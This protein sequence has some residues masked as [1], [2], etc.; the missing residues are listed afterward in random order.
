L[1]FVPCFTAGLYFHV[2][3]AFSTASSTSFPADSTTR[4]SVTSPS[5]VTTNPRRTETELPDFI[6]AARLVG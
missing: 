5:S 4:R 3:T 1:T 6:R 2:R